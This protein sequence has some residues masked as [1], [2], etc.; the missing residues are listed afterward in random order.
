MQHIVE[1]PVFTLKK[2]V[3][4]QEFLTVHEKFNREFM[5]KQKGYISHMLLKDGEKWFDIAVWESIEAKEKAFKDVYESTA[6]LELD[7]L[8]DQIGTD[9]DIPIFPVIKTY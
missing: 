5:V 6:A 9:N 1:M 2:G 4:E 8:I 7:A 3:S